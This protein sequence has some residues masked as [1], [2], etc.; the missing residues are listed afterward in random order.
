M[1]SKLRRLIKT[2]TLY[3]LNNAGE[4]WMATRTSL[5]LAE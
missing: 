3:F 5:A 4:H 1:K 2:N